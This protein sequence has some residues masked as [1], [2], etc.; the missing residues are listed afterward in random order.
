MSK[1]EDK[2]KC[3]AE[4]HTYVDLCNLSCS[5]NTEQ[6]LALSACFLLFL[7]SLSFSFSLSLLSCM[8]SLAL[9]A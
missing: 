5:K 1:N 4:V 7:L 6:Q 2:Q 9:S 8:L 3:D